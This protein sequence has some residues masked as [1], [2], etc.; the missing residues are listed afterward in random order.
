[1]CRRAIEK[2]LGKDALQW[3]AKKEERTRSGRLASV[4]EGGVWK[5]LDEEIL[6]IVDVLKEEEGS[7]GSE[8][9]GLPT[10]DEEGPVDV[11]VDGTRYGRCPSCGKKFSYSYPRDVGRLV[12]CRSCHTAMRLTH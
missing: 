1:M 9:G 5:S 4:Y 7:G 2:Y 10:G 3:L 6:K 8:R 11:P 12:R